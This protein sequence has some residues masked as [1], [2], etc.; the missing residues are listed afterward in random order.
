MAAK[1]TVKKVLEEAVEKE[2]QS[3]RL[4][5]HLMEKV[6]DRA[7]KQGLSDLALQEKKHQILFEQLLRGEIKGGALGTP[8]VIDYKIAEYFDAPKLTPD[9]KLPDIFLLAANRE[10]ISHDFYLCLGAMYS[11]GK[12][13]QLLGEVAAQELLHKQIVETLYTEVA[14]PQTDGG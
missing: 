3:Q 11:P 7:V 13:K 8:K 12:V 6:N 10:K 1:L 2:V 4:Y 14:F 5:F 9:M